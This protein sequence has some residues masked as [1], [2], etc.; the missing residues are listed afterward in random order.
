MVGKLLKDVEM[1]DA[2][3]DA[4]NDKNDTQTYREKGAYSYRKNLRKDAI[5]CYWMLL[6][7]LTPSEASLY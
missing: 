1:D 3:I 4:A 2:F 5:G 6:L 7:S